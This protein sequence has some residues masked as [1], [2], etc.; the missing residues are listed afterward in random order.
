M[1]LNVPI[2]KFNFSKDRTL[3]MKPK[4]ILF[5][6]VFLLGSLFSFAQQ[7][8]ITNFDVEVFVNKDRSIT[9]TEFISVYASGNRIKRG[10]TRN[11]PSHRNLKGRRVKMNYEILKIEKDEAKEPYFAKHTDND[12]TL[13]IGREEVFLKPGIYEYMIQYRVPN[14]IGFYNDFDEIYWNAIG[15]DVSFLVEKGSCRIT[16]PY[17]A[18]VVQQAAYTGRYGGKGEHFENTST[19]KVLDYQLTKPLKPGEGFTVAIGFSKGIMEQPGLL[20]RYGTL[21]VILL[22]LL[23]LLPYYLYTWW[24]YGQDPPTPASYAI[25]NAPDDLSSA[26]INYISNEGY[27]KNSL[28][29]SIIDLAIKGFV[30]IEQVEK[31]GMLF[32]S[33]SYDLVRLKHANSSLPEEEAALL[34]ALFAGSSRVSIDGVYQSNVEKA[35]RMHRSN[36]DAQHEAFI[37]KGNNSKFV[38]L[39]LFV[40]FV[41]GGIAFFLFANNPYADGINM[42]FIFIFAIFAVIGLI[43]YQYL[44][45]K[46]TVE[47]LELKSRIKGF[48]MYLEM[49]EKDRLNL[50]NPPDMTPQLFEAALP[51][52][53]ALGVEHQWSNLFQQILADSQYRPNW[54]NNHSHS[55]YGNFGSTFSRNA[56]QS[57]TKPSSSGSGGSGGSGF[58]GGGGGGGGVGGW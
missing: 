46:P 57:S 22:G 14:Q 23:F 58:S 8:R 26:S 56:S 30:R 34:N 43:L 42:K 12:Y 53:Y 9:V 52:A 36:L 2:P 50:L 55:F 45:K 40:S 24:R 7:E 33:D 13:Y 38:V 31:S 41:V 20:E 54:S 19:E 48:Q 3:Q 1:P 25:Y 29:A 11:F 6:L 37:S 27:N 15:T 44:I 28:T 16:L 17:N 10:I 39:P 5:S 35:C 4:Y 32:S 21:V 18:D 49:A 47:K 51:F